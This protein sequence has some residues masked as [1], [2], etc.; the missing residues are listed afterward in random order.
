MIEIKK[1]S[2]VLILAAFISA[3]ALIFLGK[4]KLDTSLKPVLEGLSIS[5]VA[6]SF[7]A[8]ILLFKK[9]T[10]KNALLFE[11]VNIILC[12]LAITSLVIYLREDNIDKNNSENIGF[13]IILS[14]AI[15]LSSMFLFNDI[16]NLNIG[17]EKKLKL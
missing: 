7:I 8:L 3:A 9:D 13:L 6:I 16:Y 11:I 10:F 4:E 5:L 14:L 15:F 17:S 12:I 2:Y 1:L